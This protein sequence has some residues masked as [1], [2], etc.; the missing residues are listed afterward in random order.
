MNGTLVMGRSGRVG[1]RSVTP[2]GGQVKKKKKEKVQEIPDSGT[3]GSHFGKL[4]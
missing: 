3:L 2:E 1:L 4:K